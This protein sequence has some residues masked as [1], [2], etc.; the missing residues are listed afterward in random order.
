VD[1]AGTF[2]LSR[3][4]KPDWG[5]D[6]S[7]RRA[8]IAKTHRILL[9]IGDDLGDFVSGAKDTPKNR[10]QL[11]QNH[12]SFWGTR[13]F[14]LPNPMYGSWDYSLYDH[15]FSLPENEILSRKFDSIEDF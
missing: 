12:G 8:A 2:V 3:D 10:V 4:E 5:S 11:V 14:L 13:W 15:N 1:S 9:L 6:K 7:S